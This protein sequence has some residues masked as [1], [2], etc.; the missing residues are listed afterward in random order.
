MN[1]FQ[2]GCTDLPA[3]AG[4]EEQGEGDGRARHGVRGRHAVLGVV[5]HLHLDHGRGGGPGPADHVLGALAQ[6]HDPDPHHDQPPAHEG[7]DVP[8]EEGEEGDVEELVAQLGSEGEQVVKESVLDHELLAGVA[9]QRIL[10]KGFHGAAS[11]GSY[12]PRPVSSGRSLQA[13]TF[14]DSTNRFPPRGSVLGWTSISLFVDFFHG[15]IRTPLP[16][17]RIH[18]LRS[19]AIFSSDKAELRVLLFPPDMTVTSP[20]VVQ[21]RPLSCLTAAGGSRKRPVYTANVLKAGDEVW[22]LQIIKQFS[23]TVPFLHVLVAIPPAQLKH[24]LRYFDC[25]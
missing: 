21:I 19:V 23:Q 20:V 14:P 7:V 17:R 4:H 24:T 10:A 12:D 15:R 2:H 5:E 3:A 25:G 11:W 22:V 13:D 16:N 8:G 9:R 6:V 1:P 18:L